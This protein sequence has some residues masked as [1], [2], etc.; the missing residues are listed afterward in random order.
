MTDTDPEYFERIV[1]EEALRAYLTDALGPADGFDVRH[2]QEGHSNETLF[3]T[4]GDRELVIR[5]PPPG[6][7]AEN[8]HDVLREYRVVDALQDTDVRVPTTVVACDDHSVIGSDFYAMEKEAGDV[9]RDAEPDRFANPAAR[10]Q[11]GYELVDRLVEIHEV[12]YE[13]V[14]LEEGD[15]GYPPGFTERQVRRWSEQLTWAFEVTSDE[16]EVNEL[17][18][19]ME[20]LYDNVPGDDEYPNTLVHGDYKLDNVMFA[21][22]DEPEIAAIFDW[23]MATL[24]DPFTDLGWMLSYWRQPKDPE[25]PT[26]SLTQTFM[27]EDGYPTRRELVDRYE[28]QTGF[29]FDNWRFYWVLATYKL[30]GLGEMFF[31]RY[32]EGNSADP[33]YPK[34]E[35]GVPALAEQALDIIDGEMT[36]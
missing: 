26:P 35:H 16:R 6:D 14:G 8:A 4:W 10:E 12:D 20:W 27:T 31:R 36:L 9:L 19:V 2:H 11:I 33:M 25:P 28:Q 24:G 7:T 22:K 18:D 30:A 34:M 21:P 1:D 5:R 23:E 15:F 13:A 29:E 3:V 17:Y 32:L